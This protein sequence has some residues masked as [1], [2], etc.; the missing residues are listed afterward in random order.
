MSHGC[1]WVPVKTRAKKS[2]KWR[3]IWCDKVVRM[4][5]SDGKPKLCHMTKP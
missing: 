5:A 3:C 2:K 4:G 1:D